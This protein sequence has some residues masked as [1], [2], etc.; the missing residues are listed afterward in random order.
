MF[1]IH[2]LDKKIM[3]GKIWKPSKNPKF[4]TKKK[5][6][7]EIEKVFQALLHS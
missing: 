6:K 7:E 1:K 3:T 2:A 4:K 5:K